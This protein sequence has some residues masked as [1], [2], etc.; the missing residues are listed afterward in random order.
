M[1]AWGDCTCRPLIRAD[2]FLAF[3]EMGLEH[4]LQMGI[5]QFGPTWM[6]PSGAVG[7]LYTPVL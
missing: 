7:P 5:F 6:R 4:L 3:A 2:R 1:N